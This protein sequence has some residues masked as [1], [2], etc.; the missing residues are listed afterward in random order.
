[1]KRTVA[2]MAVSAL[3]L[4]VAC[5]QQ[6]LSTDA[7][8]PAPP[9]PAAAGDA[10]TSQSDAT[11]SGATQS[12]ATQSGEGVGASREAAPD[13]GE[14][15]SAAPAPQP[16]MLALAYK[17]GLVVPADQVRPLME[18]HQ[19]ACERAGADQC[20]VLGA[21]ASAE[22]DEKATAELSLRATPAW[23]RVFR[24]RAEADAKDLGGR[25]DEAAT[26][27]DDLSTDIVDTEAAQRARADEEARLAQLMKRRTSSLQDTLQVEQEITRVQGEMD[28]AASEL[29]AMKTRIVMQTV[30]VSYASPAVAS[31]KGDSAPLQAA[32]RSF[33]GNVYAGLAALVWVASFLLPFALVGA[34]LAW[35][36]AR[37][38]KAT[39]AS[40]SPSLSK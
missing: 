15:P 3:A 33:M 10:K 6:S 25:I 30:T 31:P 2:L 37:R 20:Q 35:W 9:P 11:Q 18:S 19:E 7:K 13:I 8:P 32:E 21:N 4:T 39:A 36:L 38:K 28:Q 1:M 27:S 14:P 17:L 16:P 40:P 23:M 34:P 24:T 26:D 5:K 22:G 12:G 29:A